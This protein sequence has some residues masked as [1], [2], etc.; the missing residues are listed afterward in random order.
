M[1][2]VQKRCV[3]SSE[4]SNTDTLYLNKVSTALFLGPF[5]FVA[6]DYAESSRIQR[7]VT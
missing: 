6:F 5:V 4:I 3:L 7:C 1:Y 2:Q